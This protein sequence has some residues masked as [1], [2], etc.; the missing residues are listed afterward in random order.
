MLCRLYLDH[1]DGMLAKLDA[2]IE[3]RCS[4][5]APPATC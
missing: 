2:Q 1:L 3:A 4:R 5:F